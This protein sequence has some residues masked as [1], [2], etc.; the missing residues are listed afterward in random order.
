VSPNIDGLPFPKMLYHHLLHFLPL[1][2]LLN[3]T[4]IQCSILPIEAA[5]TSHIISVIHKLVS[6]KAVFGAIGHD[7]HRIK[8][9]C[10][11]IHT[12]NCM[13][14]I[15]KPRRNIYNIRDEARGMI[16]NTS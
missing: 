5:H 6:Y 13:G 11:G 4:N 3:P 1:S 14:S 10:V 15:H 2:C 12:P 7:I 9:K 16:I 8:E